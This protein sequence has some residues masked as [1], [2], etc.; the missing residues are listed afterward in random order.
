MA[1]LHKRAAFTCLPC[2]SWVFKD[3]L[4]PKFPMKPQVVRLLQARYGKTATHIEILKS[5]I[6]FLIYLFR[7][8]Q[9]ILKMIAQAFF[10][11]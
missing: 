2:E 5:S 4:G 9:N 7:M 6:Y 3:C 10:F 1:G 8:P 11:I